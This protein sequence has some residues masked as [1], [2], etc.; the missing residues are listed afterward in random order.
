MAPHCNL[1]NSFHPIP[2]C[3]WQTCDCLDLSSSFSK[4]ENSSRAVAAHSGAGLGWS[5]SSHPAVPSSG[6]SSWS[7]EHMDVTIWPWQSA[8]ARLVIFPVTSY[9][10]ASIC[11]KSPVQGGSDPPQPRWA[12]MQ[13]EPRVFLLCLPLL[14][15]PFYTWVVKGLRGRQKKLFSFWRILSEFFFRVLEVL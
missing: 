15:A 11:D 3:R 2:C 4:I 9:R 7:W 13:H 6:H 12:Q 8:T 14:W 1:W 5:R 10:N